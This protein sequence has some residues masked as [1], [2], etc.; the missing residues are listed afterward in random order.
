MGQL[1]GRQGFELLK[2]YAE[3]APEYGSLPSRVVKKA[4]GLAT[5]GLYRLT[6]GQLNLA[7]KEFLV[8]RKA[9]A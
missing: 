3:E 6:D 1:L 2:S 9:A 7:P 5:A 4:Y 8:Y